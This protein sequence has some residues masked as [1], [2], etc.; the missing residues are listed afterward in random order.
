MF[1]IDGKVNVEIT[2]AYVAE[3]KFA[4]KPD[5]DVNV[6]FD[7]C[8]TLQDEEGNYDTWYGEISDRMGFG[9]FSDWTRTDLTIKTLQDIGFGVADFSALRE[10][11]V[12]SDEGVIILPNLIGMKC[13]AVVKKSDA[14]NKNG[15]HYY[16]VRYLN[17]LGGGGPRK[18]TAA[19]VLA[20]LGE[21]ATEV[22]EP[23][24]VTE[25]AAPA[26][27]PKAKKTATVTPGPKLKPL[28]N[29]TNKH[30]F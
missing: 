14:V 8:L 11:F 1:K 21:P 27:A 2:N 28:P 23:E 5:E 24:E 10:Q 20:M 26:P 18:L 30:P 17:A 3:A 7:I 25:A 15:Q 4:A 22:V 29:T 6:Y 19:E 12:A 9:Q 13:T 16:N